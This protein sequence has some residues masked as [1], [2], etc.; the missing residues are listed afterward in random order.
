MRTDRTPHWP[1]PERVSEVVKTLDSALAALDRLIVET[2]GLV[3]R[4][5]PLE[6]SPDRPVPAA[7]NV[8]ALAVLGENLK[9][10]IEQLERW[11]IDVDFLLN[12]A[13]YQYAAA[14]AVTAGA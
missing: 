2:P 5:A 10:T 1:T 4:S 11:R 14:E 8:A 3:D 9:D 6:T 7:E 12:A 13:A